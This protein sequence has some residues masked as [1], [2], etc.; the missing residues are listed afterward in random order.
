MNIPLKNF[1][2]LAAGEGLSKAFGFVTTVYL[3]RILGAEGY[4][5]VGFTA[6]LT[7]YLALVANPGFETV[8]TREIAKGELSPLQIVSSI[9][10][11]RCGLSF[12]AFAVLALIVFLSHFSWILQMMVIIQGCHLLLVP[13]MFQFFFRGTND[14]AAVA[15]SR[16]LQSGVY[17]G[18]VL[19]FVAS[20]DD[21]LRIPAFFVVSTLA[22][23]LPLNARILKEFPLSS[24]RIDRT[25]VRKIGT[26]TLR[27]GGAALLVQVYISFDTIMLGYLRTPQEVGIYAAVYKIITILTLVPPLIFQSWLPLLS[28]LPKNGGVDAELRKYQSLLVIAGTPI[29]LIGYFLAEPVLI[30]LFGPA[31]SVGVVPFRILL[32]TVTVIYYN[33]AIANPLL[34]WG[35]EKEY[36]FIVGMGAATNIVLNIILIPQ[37]GMTGAAAATLAAEAAVLGLSL[38]ERTKRDRHSSL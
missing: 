18:L 37:F 29:F 34:A 12:F 26:H 35:K 38:Y 24:F 1:S 14:T 10:F 28:R 20:A 21:L 17:L 23:L 13:F 33:V 5:M 8:G 6:A 15:Y 19:G 4:G 27:V 16:A 30:L 9:F 22:G 32:V 25:A 2:F 31:Y 3:A 11:I 7:G 36:L